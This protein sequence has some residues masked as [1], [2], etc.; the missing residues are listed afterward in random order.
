MMNKQSLAAITALS[1]FLGGS[2]PVSLSTTATVSATENRLAAEQGKVAVSDNIKNFTDTAGHWAEGAIYE[3]VKRGYVTGYPTGKF[4]PNNKVTRAEFLKMAVSALN[5]P[6]E[7]SS[8]GSWYVKYV[9]AAKSSGV[10][11]TSDF[12]DAD[13]NKPLTRE[14]MA[15]VAVRALGSTTKVEE[16][17]WMYLATKSGIISGTSLGEISPNGVTTRAQAIS[18]IERILKVKNGVKLP[19]DKYAVAAAEVLWHKTN[20]FTVAA[21]MFDRPE[22][23]DSKAS[24]AGLNSWKKEK[25]TFTT[26]DGK[27]KAEIQQL[28]VIDMADPKDP[29]RRL[30]PPIKELS[31]VSFTTEKKLKEVSDDYVI[32]LRAKDIFI[33]DA[34][35]YGNGLRFS[36]GGFVEDEAGLTTNSPQILKHRDNFLDAYIVSKSKFN[37]DKTK[38]LRIYIEAPG[39]PGAPY[40][41]EMIVKSYFEK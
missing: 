19:A 27:Y 40:K 1:V 8:S 6:V 28:I 34:K 38:M 20:I 12:A 30:L 18:V 24:N 39:R 2:L 7:S 37:V 33:K 11:V 3:A 26:D 22:N 4:L 25:L 13:W 10:F 5:L 29:N 17:Q 35:R 23:Y 14:E 15:K 21:A 9:D 36:F 16:N 31:W 41:N 32:L